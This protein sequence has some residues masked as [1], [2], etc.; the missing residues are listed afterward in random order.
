MWALKLCSG[1]VV[2]KSYTWSTAWL[3]LPRESWPMCL[4]SSLLQFFHF[5][6]CLV[7]ANAW[8]VFFS[9]ELAWV[10]APCGSHCWDC[11]VAVSKISD[12]RFEARLPSKFLVSYGNRLVWLCSVCA[13]LFAFLLLTLLP[14]PQSP[15]YFEFS[16]CSS[17]LCTPRIQ[18][19][20][21]KKEIE[22]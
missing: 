17:P 19:A 6:F 2:F 1:T 7:L 12:N 21:Y 3:Y 18:Q 10:S 16:G 4:M 11:T 22:S 14:S 9:S 20:L 13:C 15:E 8:I 5:L